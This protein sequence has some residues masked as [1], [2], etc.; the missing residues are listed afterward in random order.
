MYISIQNVKKRKS[1][2]LKDLKYKMLPYPKINVE[3]YKCI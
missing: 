2:I 1:E 3:N